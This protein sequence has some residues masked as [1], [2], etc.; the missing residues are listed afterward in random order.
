MLKIEKGPQSWA[1]PLGLLVGASSCEQPL[2]GLSSRAA[3]VTPPSC[4]RRALGPS[5]GTMCYSSFVS[6]KH[7]LCAPQKGGSA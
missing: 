2:P 5:K 4:S 1:C 6:W 7:P 3:I